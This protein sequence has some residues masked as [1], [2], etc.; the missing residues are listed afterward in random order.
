MDR[1]APL[2]QE[3]LA[4]L[5]Q[6]TETLLEREGLQGLVI[7]AGVPQRIFLDDMDYPFKANPHF[8]HW[9]PVTDNPHC[10]LLIRPVEKPT[11]LFY[12]PVDFWH[13]VPPL[14]QG[15]WTDAVE[16]KVIEKPEQARALLPDDLSAYAFI[17]EPTELAAQWGLDRVNPQ[18]VM[19]YLHYHRAYKTDY[20]LA[21]LRVASEIAVCGHE[22]ARDAF[23]GQKSEFD[24]QLAYLS[25]TAQGENEVPYGNI[26]A[27][28]EN[29]AILHYTALERVAPKQLRSFLLDAGASFHGYASDITRTYA[30]DPASRF[31]ELVAAMNEQQL[32]IIDTIK[33]GM[34]YTELH[35]DMHQRVAQLLSRFELARGSTEAL[36][37]EGVTAAFF[38]HGLGHQIGL[39]VHDVGGFMQ[40]ELGTHLAAP[41][42]HPA[43]RC[44]R[45][46]EP[47]MVLTIEPGLYV[48]DTLLNNLSDGAKGMLN[49]SVIDE[50]RPY[51]GIR[52]EDDVVLH[53][54]RIENLTRDLGLA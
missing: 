48:I 24:I 9:V 13:K 21:C 47:G 51:G 14:P 27:L 7:H 19:D 16:I 18:P 49:T 38:P 6:R 25:A 37:A 33:P 12:R 23:F 3:H 35:L 20:E 1:F 17:G 54:D 11:L 40:D 36:I 8:K 2:Y 22:A 53:G 26:V 28:N 10:V 41:Q 45:M 30:F 4:T 34:A 42:A 32:A 52:I 31:A 39:Q 29:S 5:T 44:T 46:L 15:F 50:L 43:L